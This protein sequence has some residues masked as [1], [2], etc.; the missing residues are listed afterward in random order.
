MWG[1][2]VFLGY[3]TR[4]TTRGNQLF[5]IIGIPNIY[6]PKGFD[7]MTKFVVITWRV[8]CFIHALL[9]RHMPTPITHLCF[10]LL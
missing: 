5:L 3:Q 6:A 10:A 7:L 9:R 2:R 1:R 8:A 4:P